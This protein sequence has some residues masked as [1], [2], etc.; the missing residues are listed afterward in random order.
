MREK[1]TD[2]PPI[3]LEEFYEEYFEKFRDE[4]FFES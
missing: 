1:M 3:R 2:M 4:T